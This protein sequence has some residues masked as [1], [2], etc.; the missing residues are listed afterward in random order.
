MK[1]KEKKAKKKPKQIEDISENFNLK[2]NVVIFLSKVD[3][4]KYLAQKNLME[5]NFDDAIYN[6]EKI[7]RLA[8]LAD[9]PSYIKEQEDFINSIA[10]EVQNDYLISEIE[11][12]SNSINN[13]YDK[14]IEFNQINQAHEIVKS[15]IQRYQ[16]MPFF[17]SI[18]SVRDLMMRDK[19]VWIQYINSLNNEN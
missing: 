10:K 17:D 3:K 14:L 1:K 5:G 8:I 16:D 13:M 19:K 18:T 12:T 2:D 6:A 11:K 7:I 15:F 9:M 4:L